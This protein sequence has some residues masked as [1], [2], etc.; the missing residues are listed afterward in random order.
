MSSG[1]ATMHSAR[2]IRRSSGPLKSF[3]PGTASRLFQ[4]LARAGQR[5]RGGGSAH[6]PGE[7]PGPLLVAAKLPDRYHVAP[8]RAWSLLHH[9][10]MVCERSD[11]REVGHHQ[12][13][14]VRTQALEP[15]PDL[16]RGLASN[17]R[18]DLVVD[19]GGQPVRA[20]A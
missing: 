1:C 3:L 13:L 20:R 12:D 19:D 18:S 5:L 15:Q 4:Q 9:E 2:L 16:D 10:V 8:I 17:A 14:V 6:H 7:L 11:L